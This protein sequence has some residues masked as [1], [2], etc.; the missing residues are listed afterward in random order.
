MGTGL[1]AYSATDAS[2]S[3]GLLDPGSLVLVDA[4]D[5][6][7]H[8]ARSLLAK[9]DNSLWT[10][11]RASAASGTFLLVHHRKSG[12][13]IHRDR[14]EL[15]SGHTVPAT[16]ATIRA[17]GVT[18]IERRLHLAGKGAVVLTGSR[19]G[20]A[21][22]VTTDHSHHR[23]L[24]LDLVAEDLGNL[25]HRLVASDRTVVIVQIRRLHR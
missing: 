23:G 4:G 1:R 8:T 18:G 16:K 12:L 11:L 24:L 21:C 17:T 6:F 25:L 10:G 22:A 9:L 5:I 13:G 15:T 7:P 3:A 19:S 2:V 14:P 20:G